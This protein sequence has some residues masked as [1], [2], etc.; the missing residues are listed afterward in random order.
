M[1]VDKVDADKYIS[2]CL[3]FSRQLP[4]FR[5]IWQ[6]D[7]VYELPG[8]LSDDHI[9]DIAHRVM[10]DW[11][12]T[13]PYTE[14]DGTHC[15]RCLGQ[16]FWSL[17]NHPEFD[18]VFDPELRAYMLTQYRDINLLVENFCRTYLNRTPEYV[19]GIATPGF[20][21][22]TSDISGT[23][24][25]TDGALVRKMPDIDVNRIISVIIPIQSDA[26]SHTEFKI[27]DS[28]TYQATLTPGD[29]LI[30]PGKVTHRIGCQTI[31]PG[32][33]RITYQCHIYDDHDRA[34]IHF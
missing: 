3:D 30:W 13:Y 22:I 20:N 6:G 10:S 16:N 14:S 31:Q 24:W 26:S 2:G 18:D 33:D 21:I 27:S 19:S 29:I 32:Q 17:P 34:L 11:H 12:L 9:S 28:Q 15:I 7:A 8:F 25:H 23:H 1:V 5:D 4:T